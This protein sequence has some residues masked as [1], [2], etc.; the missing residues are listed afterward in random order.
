MEVRVI[1]PK[2]PVWQGKAKQVVLPAEEGEISLLDFHQPLLTRL[3]NGYVGIDSEQIPIED[4]TALLQ[5]NEL[6]ILITCRT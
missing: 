4:G 5:E 2:G 3:K 1:E 6:I